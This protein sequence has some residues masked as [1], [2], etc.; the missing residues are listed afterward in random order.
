MSAA[1]VKWLT[2][3][4][5]ASG[6]SDGNSDKRDTYL[7]CVGCQYCIAHIAVLNLLLIAQYSIR[8]GK[9]NVHE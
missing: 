4:I 7:F 2:D 6:N 8:L 1:I 5:G 3:D 9:G